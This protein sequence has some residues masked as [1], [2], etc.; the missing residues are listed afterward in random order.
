MVSQVVLD[1]ARFEPY[2]GEAAHYSY[3]RD[4]TD[5]IFNEDPDVRSFADFVRRYVPS[6]VPYQ[7]PASEI[8]GI[9]DV[10]KQAVDPR[11]KSV[12]LVRGRVPVGGGH[13]DC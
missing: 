7:K 2:C 5:D 9:F 13:A 8:A 10:A 6:S 3:W 4:K 12:P 1:E 11:D